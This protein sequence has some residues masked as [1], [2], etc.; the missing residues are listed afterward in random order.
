MKGM[1]LGILLIIVVG[2]GGLVYRNAVEHPFQSIACPTTQFT[3]PDGTSVSHI[4][5]SCEFPACPPPN[6]TIKEMGISY[7][8]PEGFVQMELADS[9][10]RLSDTPTTPNLFDAQVHYGSAS[11]GTDASI[12]IRR[13][14]LT[15]SSTALSLIQK[16][17]IGAAS[18]LPVSATSFTSTTLHNRRFTVVTLER[19]EG[20]IDTAYYLTR[21]TD[22]LRFDAVD[23]GVAN[24]TDPDLNQSALPAH[25]ALI[26]LLSSLQGQ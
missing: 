9:L 17:A 20:V 18:G 1:F 23:R 7:V 15:G 13:Y 8:L 24:W 16:T 12:F 26:K 4:A 10:D 19:F 22:V 25:A 21:G 3:C 2:V 5:N 11:G 6:V 14:P